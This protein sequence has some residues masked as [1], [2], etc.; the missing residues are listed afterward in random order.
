M[1]F[2]GYCVRFEDVTSPETRI[3]YMTDGM[4]LREAISDPLLSRYSVL[5]LDEVHERTIHTDVL[6]G[7]A[8]SAQK[9]RQNSKTDKPLKVCLVILYLKK[10]I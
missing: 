1:W 9:L 6:L 10:A 4:L 7:I 5:I 2:Q 3:K 8:K